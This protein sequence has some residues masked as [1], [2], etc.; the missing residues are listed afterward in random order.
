MPIIKRNLELPR[1]KFR[2]SGDNA[3]GIVWIVLVLGI[4]A[5]ILKHV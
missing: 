1:I 4:V 2:G 5:A 3:E